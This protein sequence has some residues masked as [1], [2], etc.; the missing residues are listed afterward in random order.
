MKRLPC[1]G[2]EVAELAD[3]EDSKSSARKGVGVRLPS[4]AV[5]HFASKGKALRDFFRATP[6]HLVAHVRTPLTTF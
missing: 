1:V 3:A 2:A 5:G 4:S 6:A